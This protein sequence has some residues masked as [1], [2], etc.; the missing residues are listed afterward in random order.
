MRYLQLL[1]F[2]LGLLTY[3]EHRAQQFET[4]NYG[5]TLGSNYKINHSAVVPGNGLIAAGFTNTP[6]SGGN[7]VFLIRYDDSGSVLWA[8]TYGPGEAYHI[9][10]SPDGDF[11]IGGVIRNPYYREDTFFISRISPEGAVKWRSKLGVGVAYPG[12]FSLVCNIE[13]GPDGNYAIMGQEY[14][15]RQIFLKVIDASTGTLLNEHYIIAKN[16]LE[17]N[18]FLIAQNGDYLV[19]YWTPDERGVVERLKPD[20][21]PLWKR[22]L[23]LDYGYF[24]GFK[25]LKILERKNGQLVIGGGAG[26]GGDL[27]LLKPDGTLDGQVYLDF[28]LS[29]YTPHRPEFFEDLQGDLHVFYLFQSAANG[30]S[31]TNYKHDVYYFRLDKL[32]HQKEAQKTVLGEDLSGKLLLDGMRRGYWYSFMFSYYASSVR[33]RPFN[34]ADLASGWSPAWVYESDLPPSHEQDL[35]HVRDSKGIHWILTTLRHDYPKP[36]HYVVYKV[37]DEGKVLATKMLPN[38]SRSYCGSIAADF[39]DGSCLVASPGGYCWKL[40][41]E[42]N[43]VWEKNLGGTSPVRCGGDNFILLGAN[44][45][46]RYDSNG[47]LVWEKALGSANIQRI[48]PR[49]D[50]IIVLFGTLTT[51]IERK[52]WVA[53][54]DPEAGKIREHVLPGLSNPDYVASATISKY[55]NSLI[56]ATEKSVKIDSTHWEREILVQ[57]ISD[58]SIEWTYTLRSSTPL[59]VIQLHQA[60]CGGYV[61]SGAVYDARYREAH[62]FLLHEISE[63][64]EGGKFCFFRKKPFFETSNDSF[65]PGFVYREWGIQSNGQTQDLYFHKLSFPQPAPS[66]TQDEGDM[67]LFP[68]P[69]D[70]NLCITFNAAWR[71]PFDVDILDFKGALAASF[72]RVK[73]EEHWSGHYSGLTLARGV[74][75]VRIR[76][77]DGQC[78]TKKWVR[79]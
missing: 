12:V 25:E 16:I 47:K 15:S 41:R 70:G 8:Q 52:G 20:F 30:P 34:P 44:S 33:I 35:Y 42:T 67:T 28:G 17:A 38:D 19:Y 31:Y 55:D 62:D 58:A 75:V 74:Y 66:A 26:S 65:S 29:F 68:N 53:Y 37:S 50:G 3:T 4:F 2:T 9:T 6:D 54:L 45:L 39:S 32:N 22:S 79:L 11:V 13:V 63:K 7:H 24:S 72:K 60:P 43:V 69:S 51:D 64:G 21:T 18:G 78:L 76:T 71:G 61:L 56:T 27:L 5:E 1:A 10:A 77:E 46:R 49:P 48:L 23:H 40:D 59:E 14:L 36:A 73:Q 57:K